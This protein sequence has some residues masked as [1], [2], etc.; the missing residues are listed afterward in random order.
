MN[1]HLLS[2]FDV[3]K[4][5]TTEPVAADGNEIG[6]LAIRGN[7]V[8]KGYLKNR[9]ATAE[10]F[11]GGWF[12]TGDLG[13]KY[14]D[15]YIKIMDRLKDIIISG[16]E[17]ISSI[18]VENVLYRMPEIDSCAVVAAPHE[19][20]GEVPVAF[21]EICEGSTLDREDIINHCRKHL[22]G[23]QVPKHIIFAQI[24]KTSTGK[25]QKFELRQAARSMAHEESKITHHHNQS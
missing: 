20:W 11:E 15:G 25:V 17:N 24:P 16:G 10:V 14:P 3:F 7:M 13:V 23:F 12:K 6:E 22:A 8:M 9:K 18:E 19:K 5:G 2:G 21:V 1:S 4:Q